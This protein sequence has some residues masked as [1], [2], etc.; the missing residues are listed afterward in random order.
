M[1]DGGLAIPVIRSTTA[2]ATAPVWGRVVTAASAT[3]GRWYA[4]RWRAGIDRIVK[5][6]F[7]LQDTA[8]NTVRTGESHFLT[9]LEY[10]FVSCGRDLDAWLGERCCIVKVGIDPSFG[11]CVRRMSH[12][13]NL[14]KESDRDTVSGITHDWSCCLRRGNFEG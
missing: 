2:A 13:S 3:A 8:L 5:D 14:L 12:D 1:P 11:S 4:F 9:R 7:A 10:L 6:E